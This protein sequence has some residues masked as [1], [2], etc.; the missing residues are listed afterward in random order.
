MKNIGIIVNSKRARS[1]KTLDI[2]NDLAEKKS[3][4]LFVIQKELNSFINSTVLEI[5][6][7]KT[8]VEIVMALGGDGTVLFSAEKLIGTQIPILGINLGSL[9]FLAEVNES[10]IEKAIEYI[11]KNKFR[12]TNRTILKPTLITQ[13]KKD[14]GDIYSV[15][16]I[17][18]GWGGSSRIITLELFIDHELAGIFT[19]DGI[20]IS[21]PTGSTGHNLSNGGPIVHKD[22]E[23]ICIS[24]ICPHTLSTRPLVIPNE[25]DIEIRIKKSSKEV[26]I[27]VDGHDYLSLVEGDK[28][29]ISKHLGSVMFVQLDGYSYFNT[30]MN[31]LNWQG[32]VI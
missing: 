18:I 13:G 14:L 31:K 24:V 8:Q 12:L 1:I 6:E 25:S 29:K 32:S 10:E 19:C 15:N 21:T 28:V 17:V 26:I 23:G 9:G 4:N 20:I 27:A 11:V 30:L 5:E 3:L 22:V 7:F 16:D 2:L